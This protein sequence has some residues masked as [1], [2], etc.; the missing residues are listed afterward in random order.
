MRRLLLSAAALCAAAT[1]SV[2]LL[3]A[4]VAEPSGSAAH[5]ALVDAETLTAQ[6]LVEQAEPGDLL[7]AAVVQR[8]AGVVMTQSVTPAAAMR[9]A[10][11]P[12]LIVRRVGAAQIVNAPAFHGRVRVPSSLT[13]VGWL[14]TS[15]GPSA[16]KGTTALFFHRDRGGGGRGQ[17]H[18][19][20]EAPR[21]RKGHVMALRVNGATKRFRVTRVQ[22]VGRGRLPTSLVDRQ[23]KRRIALI[24]CGGPLRLG[25][26]GVWRWSRQSVTWA[27]PSRS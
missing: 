17:H 14:T 12:S 1:V 24:T 18:R 3:D 21:L 23:G 5:G 8:A 22:H 25:T 4:D 11:R 27:Q 26:D 20:F 15:A 16:S 2:S 7:P 9:K 19:L 6:R 13:Q 10:K